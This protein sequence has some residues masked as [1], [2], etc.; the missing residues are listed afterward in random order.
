MALPAAM[1]SAVVCNDT[2]DESALFCATTAPA[3]PI[4]IMEGVDK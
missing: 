2:L 1:Y 4:G 3:A